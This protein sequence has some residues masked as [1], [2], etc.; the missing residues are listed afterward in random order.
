MEL[1]NSDQGGL[2]DQ[3][4]SL[5]VLFK[6]VKVMCI[7]TPLLAKEELSSGMLIFLG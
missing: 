4:I 2:M 7:I 6:L 3:L 5:N 1:G